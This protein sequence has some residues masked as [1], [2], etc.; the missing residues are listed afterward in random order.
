[1]PNILLNATFLFVDFE[2]KQKK[3]KRFSSMNTEQVCNLISFHFAR[4]YTALAQ[5]NCRLKKGYP[6]I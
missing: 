6:L 3:K 5:V 1:M 2:H 4:N